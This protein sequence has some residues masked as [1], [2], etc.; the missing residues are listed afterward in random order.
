[1]LNFLVFAIKLSSD[2]FLQGSSI[3]KLGD[4]YTQIRCPF[5]CSF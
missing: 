5:H 2:F 4:N 3:Y 1:M